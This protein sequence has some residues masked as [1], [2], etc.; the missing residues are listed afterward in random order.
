MDAIVFCFENS[1]LDLMNPI[2]VKS[3][4][5]PKQLFAAVSIDTGASISS[6]EGDESSTQNG[7]R[8]EKAHTEGTDQKPAGAGPASGTTF[9]E[10]YQRRVWQRIQQAREHLQHLYPL[11]YRVE[12]LENIFSLLFCRHSD[13]LEGVL[14]MDGDSDYDAEGESKADSMENLNMSIISEEDAESEKLTNSVKDDTST[15]SSLLRQTDSAIS[16]LGLDGKCD[17]SSSVEYDA[18]FQEPQ[19]ERSLQ[20]KHSR[21]KSHDSSDNWKPF[22]QPDYSYGFL[23][24]DYVVR[25]ILAMLKEALLDL[26]AVRFKMQGQ[27]Q[28]ECR[29]AAELLKQTP[30]SSAKPGT[31][32]TPA[33]VPLPDHR[34]SAKSSRDRG[35]SSPSPDKVNKGVDPGDP[36]FNPA[37]EK[38]LSHTVSTSITKE[39]LQKRMA[40]LTQHI[41]EAQWRFQLVAHEKIP[42]QPGCVLEEVVVVTDDDSH[43]ACISDEWTSP[44]RPQSAGELAFCLFV[45]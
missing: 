12:I 21:L 3:V 7:G 26:S 30:H 4:V 44:K 45:H 32:A 42:R 17:R 19:T 8:S 5:K 11:A 25:D 15:T 16:S 37:L 35:R 34:S 9:Q 24:N 31:M 33:K 27:A 43:V 2:C 22:S 20:P 1:D 6:S 13:I 36:D 40:Q 28:E 10:M 38:L 14:M 41:H 23:A 18:P 29:Q 39:T